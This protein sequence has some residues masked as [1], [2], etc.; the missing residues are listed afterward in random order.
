M[1]GEDSLHRT[2]KHA[3]FSLRQASLAA[4]SRVNR[5]SPLDQSISPLL[6]LPPQLISS[7]LISSHSISRT[8]DW[9]L[10][11]KLSLNIQDCHLSYSVPVGQAYS[12][13]QVTWYSVDSLP[14]VIRLK[15]HFY[16]GFFIRFRSLQPC[17]IDKYTICSSVLSTSVDEDSIITYQYHRVISSR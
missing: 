2:N 10:A 11:K 6:F 1:E 17:D 16:F 14:K 13:N 4:G 8:S 9:T 12:W 15:Q 5:F 7:R 3:L